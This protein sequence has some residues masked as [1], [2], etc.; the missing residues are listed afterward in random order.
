MLQLGQQQQ[1]GLRHRW[2]LRLLLL[3]MQL[4]TLLAMLPLRCVMQ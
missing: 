1:T 2:P 3:L 4:L